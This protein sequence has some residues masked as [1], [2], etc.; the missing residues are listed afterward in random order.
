VIATLVDAEQL[1]H[2]LEPDVPRDP[3]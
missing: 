1:H 3:E 2:K